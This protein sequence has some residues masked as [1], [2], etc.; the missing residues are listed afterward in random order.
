MTD[1]T[2]TLRAAARLLEAGR[3]EAALAAL[4]PLLS[5]ASVPAEARF[6]EARALAEADRPEEARA[7]FEAALAAA[8][9]EPAVWME[10]ALLA[11]RLGDAADLRGRARAAGL[12]AALTGMIDAAA[13]GQGARATGTGAATKR[14]VAALTKA[15]KAGDAR[16]AE[17]VARPLLARQP[18]AAVWQLLGQA[19]LQAGAAAPAA[20]AF[21][22]GARLEPYAADLR[23]GRARAQARAGEVASALAEA[24]RA[25]RLAPGWAEA[26]LVFG[27]LALAQRLL[28][29]AARAAEA[30]LA[31]APRADAAL[32]LAAEVALARGRAA[33]AMDHAAARAPDA[34]E[35]DLL[36]GHAAAAAR[37]TEDALAA[38]AAG[39][40]RHPDDSDLR[41]ARAQL[42]QSEGRTAEA[43]ADLGAVL[44]RAPGHGTA[45]RALAYGRRLDPD[46]PAVRGM[47]KALD[48]PAT[49]AEDR[50]L[51]HYALARVLERADPAA[52]FDHLDAAN[53]ATA[54]RWP[55]SPEADR[56][57]LARMT[58]PDW[59]AIR[60]LQGESACEAAPVFVTGL[61]RSGTTLVEAILSSHSAMRAG[62]ELAV[63]GP[64]LAEL[65]AK[66]RDGAGAE[67]LTQAGEAYAVRAE[68]A[69]GGPDP[70]RTTDKSIH[71]YA[72]AGQALRILPRARIVVVHRDPRDVALSIWRNH[73]RDGTHRYAATA[74]GIA[75]HIA[76]FREAVAFWREALGPGA[77]H[78]I[79][80]EALLDDPEG[81]AR[82]MLAFC[83]LDWE[84][85]V[86]AFH[87]RAE[88]VATLSFA[89][90]RQPLYRSSKG[91]WR[92]HEA[93]IRPLLDALEARGVLDGA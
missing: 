75:D 42:L 9:K 35:R 61:P 15:A 40:A 24:R 29:H 7:A 14:D 86:L 79:H 38:F 68:A 60:D 73:F 43:E 90:V 74:E 18:G 78:D 4:S 16:T 8:P 13:R 80:Y 22:Q 52:A 6:L 64:V 46:D 65:S 12:P 27:R 82:R 50:R 62:G 1:P 37:R 56:A 77:L 23:L 48:D 33:E 92:A 10:R 21:A 66:L 53:A 31:A 93:R 59:E 25:A 72:Q 58:G 3:A 36:L 11:W 69:A 32:R 39:L 81:E 41:T 44:A 85:E 89:Q 30:A 34:P 54:A 17:A 19:R 87:E 63:L 70:R 47:R 71:T 2:E 67:V 57:D 5:G 76:L 55:H 49:G 91:G 45:A 84:R 20:E 51:L 88:R 28:D 83:G 26:Q